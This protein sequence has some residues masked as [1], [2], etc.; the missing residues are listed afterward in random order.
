MYEEYEEHPRILEL[1]VIS[2]FQLIVREYNLNKAMELY[3]TM[4]FVLDIDYRKLSAILVQSVQ[5]RRQ[6]HA[7]KLRSRQ[8]LVFMGH[9]FGENRMFLA[10]D[11]MNIS[12]ATL[13]RRDSELRVDDF[14]TPEWLKKLD[15]DVVV[16]GIPQYALEAK[17]FIKE[18]DRYLGVLGHVFIPKTEL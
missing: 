2:Y 3:K 1:R 8:E 7:D 4:C 13:Y 10:L 18:F 16:C 6:T 14:V 17:R 11:L 15:D 5:V 12:K 9:L